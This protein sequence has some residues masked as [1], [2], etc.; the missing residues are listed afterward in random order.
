MKS[1]LRDD[2]C[3]AINGPLILGDRLKGR[4][5]HLPSVSSLNFLLDLHLLK[6]LG[7]SGHEPVLNLVFLN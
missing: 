4:R 3:F 7:H 2:C 6:W 1:F 5:D